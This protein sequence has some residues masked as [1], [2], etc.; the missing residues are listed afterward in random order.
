MYLLFSLMLLASIPFLF[1]DEV[2]D[3]IRYILDIIGLLNLKFYAKIV[4]H[5][6]MMKKYGKHYIE[7]SQHVTLDDD[8]EE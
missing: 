5:K 2:Y 7:F 4:G 3:A 1:E 6:Q 8:D